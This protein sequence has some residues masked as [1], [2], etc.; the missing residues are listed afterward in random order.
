MTD[1]RL[2][3]EHGTRALAVVQLS[4]RATDETLRGVLAL[5]RAAPNRLAAILDEH[6][7][8]LIAFTA[9]RRI[10]S[11]NAGAEDF[12]RY[13]RHELDGRTTDDIVPER[14]RQPD[15]PPQ[16]AT[17]DLTTVEL[18]GLRRDG[19][20]IPTVWTFGF[21]PGPDGPV[22]VLLA[23]DRVQLDDALDAL[24]DSEERF[25]FLVEGIRDYA[26][27]MLDA[28][29]R[30]STWNENAARI[31]GWAASEVLG[32]SYESFFAPEDRAAGEPSRL[33]GIALSEGRVDATGWRVRRD[34]SRF[35]VES[36]LTA[37]AARDGSPRGYAVITH[38]LSERVRARETERRLS[39]AQTAR[40]TAEAAEERARQS[41]HRVSRLHRM[42]L[43]LSNALTPQEVADATMSECV[44]ELDAAG[45]A[46]YA[47]GDDGRSLNLLAQFGHP[48][49]ALE[50]FY[51]L[52][53]TLRSPL[54][55]VFRSGEPAFYESFE[56]YAERYPDL[57]APMSVGGFGASVALPLVAPGRGAV[58]VL[59]IRYKGVRRFDESERSLLMTMSKMCSQALERSLLFAAEKRA[60]NEAEAA[61][62]AKD[63]FLAM[64]S[65]ELRTP[66]NSILGWASILRRELRDE[67]Q[68]A[69]GLEVIERNAK[70]QARIV[71]DLLDMSGII[72][73]KLALSLTRVSLWD[74]VRA[75]ADVVRPAA[76]SKGVRLIVDVD[77]DLPS[78]DGDPARLQQVVWNLLINAVRFTARGG[79]ISVTGEC[80]DTTVS[81]Q[82]EDTG[83]GISPEHLP[84]VF[85]RFR[86]VDS[87]TTRTHGGLG[88]GLAIVRHLVEAHGGSVEARSDGL[89]HGSTFTLV[90]PAHAAPPRI[91]ETNGHATNGVDRRTPPGPT[92]RL[93]RMR[94]LVVE[95][96]SDSLELFSKVL[97]DAGAEVTAVGSA[98][99][100]LDARG[101][102]DVIVSDLGMPVLDGFS[103]IRRI[104][105]REQ[106][107][108]TPAL[109]LTAYAR[110]EDGDL[111]R[112][113]GFQE[114]LSKPVN[115]AALVE[116]VARWRR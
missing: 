47:R 79:R 101:P 63:E 28:A 58:G 2:S 112:Q 12:F 34:G 1:G 96:D 17:E 87:S 92:G 5:V 90:L 44:T 19:S 85:E 42:V 115:P 70:A 82:V 4:Q 102:F 60:R 8:P 25:R 16:L 33:L 35:Q 51:S 75:A 24:R 11:A 71:S 36:F 73:G 7:E 103:L 43:A 78:I 30:V 91:S 59:G 95:D 39:V 93:E 40:A 105:S 98:H 80:V 52:P 99:E 54:L 84:F 106:D 77:P 20:E 65:H 50:G 26:L 41:E 57:R 64:V 13:A 38:D 81:L 88:L 48:Q 21:A 46:V 104:R 97:Q 94:V 3:V 32:R 14:L 114:H 83:T 31:K 100:A 66:L 27:F 69:R 37:L 74:V 49:E 53:V 45:G 107:R 111:A 67:K 76:E 10:L 68:L 108:D 18:P 15:A 56:A 89:G 116:A 62:R 113:S 9:E 29:G 61:N 86:Q 23:R 109:A 72:S 55:D 110:D 6:A 22:F